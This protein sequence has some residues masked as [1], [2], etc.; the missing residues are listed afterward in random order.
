MW[1][2]IFGAANLLAM[3]AWAV[4]ILAPRRESV[5]SA[6][7][8]GP[9]LLLAL[10][11]VLGLTLVLT[12]IVPTGGGA[13]FSTIKGVRSIFASDPGV[14]IGWVHYLAFDLFVGLWIA[15]N[16][17]AHGLGTLKGRLVQAPILFFTFAAGPFGLALYI[18]VRTI[19]LRGPSDRRIPA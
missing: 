7:F 4:L 13:D 14:T 18:V 9:L 6:L 12:G 1:E 5:M 2:Q 11:Y 15:R 8:F 3:I 19:L 16:A 17:D 10:G